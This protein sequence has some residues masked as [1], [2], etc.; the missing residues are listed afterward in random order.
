MT[1]A[2]I[3]YKQES[4]VIDE[5]QKEYLKRWRDTLK[6]VANMLKKHQSLEVKLF[7]LQ[8]YSIVEK[9]TKMIEDIDNDWRVVKRVLEMD[10]GDV[11]E[12]DEKD[13][14]IVQGFVPKLQAFNE[15]YDKMFEELKGYFNKYLVEED[16]K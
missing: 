14:A 15:A 16:L 3:D 9:L 8:G 1:E 12:V 4:K 2:R 13:V 6:M 5:M 7:T 11:V 10:G